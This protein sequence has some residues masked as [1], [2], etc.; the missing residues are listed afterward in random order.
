[1]NV[2]QT[3]GSDD[4]AKK[5]YVLQIGVL[6]S[7]LEHAVPEQMFVVAGAF[8]VL[9]TA[10]FSANIAFGLA[11]ALMSAWAIV[12]LTEGWLAGCDS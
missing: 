8:G 6:S 5:N 4:Q 12:E 1:M 3:D 2:A 9:T 10:A 7:A 11:I